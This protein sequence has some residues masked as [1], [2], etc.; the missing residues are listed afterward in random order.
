MNM[1]EISQNEVLNKLKKLLPL[2]TN[3]ELE[4]LYAFEQGLCLFVESRKKDEHSKEVV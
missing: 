1:K 4:R 2:L 3:S